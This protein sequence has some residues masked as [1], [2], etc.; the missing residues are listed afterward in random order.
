MVRFTPTAAQPF[1]GSFTIA[2]NDPATPFVVVNLSGIGT[3]APVPNLDIATVVINFPNG[4]SSTAVEI[5]NTGDAD[6]V[7]ASLSV[8]ALPFSFSGNPAF[9]AVFRPG[10]GFVLTVAFSPAAPGVYSSEMLLV[11]NDP[12]QLLTV[13]RLRGTSTPQDELFKLKAPSA[14]MYCGSVDT[15]AFLPQRHKYRYPLSATAV[16]GG[17]LPIAA[18]EKGDLLMIPRRRIG[19]LAGHLHSTR[20]A[21]SSESGAKRNNYLAAADSHGLR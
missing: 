17:V 2:S 18:M 7:I 20:W 21:E 4:T 1:A 8:P 5:R 11:S 19:T 16:P 6:L 9:P 15:V 14:V 10:E 12:D 13:F 3:V